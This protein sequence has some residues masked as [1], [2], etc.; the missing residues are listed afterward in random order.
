MILNHNISVSY[1]SITGTFFLESLLGKHWDF[2]PWGL[3]FQKTLLSYE[4]NDM[5]RF[6]DAQ[7]AVEFSLLKFITIEF[8]TIIQRL[9]KIYW[10]LKEQIYII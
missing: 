1:H 6:S 9:Q 5:A 10:E 2:D 7:S 4:P 3:Y 8:Q